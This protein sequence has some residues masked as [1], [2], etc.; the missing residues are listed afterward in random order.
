VRFGGLVAVDDASVAVAEGSITGLIGPNGAG[1]TTMFNAIAGF[2]T[3][4]EG[5]VRLNGQDVTHLAVHERATRGMGRTFQVLQLIPQLTVHDNLLIATHGANPTGVASHVFVTGPALGAELRARRTVDAVVEQLGLTG[6]LDRRVADLPFGTLRMIELARALVTGSPLVMLDEPASGLDTSETDRFADLLRS[7]RDDAGRSLLLIEH[8]VRMVMSV[9]DHVYVL[10]RG[11]I[12][13]S[14]TPS[15]VQGDEAVR[16]A[17]LGRAEE[18]GEDITTGRES[19]R[20][21]TGGGG[22]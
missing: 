20:L 9:C 13:A 16:A 3:P 7:L 10:D 6:A 18:G 15:Q 22:G 19:E 21:A 5:T 1:K 11:R 4:A 2:V 12:I 14:G 8:D 17:Y